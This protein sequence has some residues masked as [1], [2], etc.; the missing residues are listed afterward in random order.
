MLKAFERIRNFGVFDDYS[1]PQDLE[2]FAELNLIYGWNYAGKTTLSRV[3]RSVETQTLHQDYSV[4]RFE[5]STSGNSSIT[6]SSLATASEKIRV[7]NSDFVRDNL[8]WDGE[9]FE[10]ILLLGQQ[11]IEAQKEITTNDALLERLREGYRKK[12]AAIKDHDDALRNKKTERARFIKQALQLVEAFTATHLNQELAK[13]E[14]D[15]AE[16]LVTDE[17]LPRLQQLA[18]ADEKG[19]LPKIQ[20]LA[21]TLSASKPSE[22]IAELLNRKPAMSNT[23]GY[24]AEHAEVANWIRTG[25]PLHDSKDEC[26]FCGNPLDSKRLVSLRAH[27][28]KDVELLESA[29]KQKKADVQRLKLTVA[30]FH[31]SDFYAQF[32]ESL[33]QAQANLKEAISSYNDFL[34]SS[35]V[36]IDEKLLSLFK[37]FECPQYIKGLATAVTQATKVVNA[38]IDENNEVTDTFG[39]EK[40]NAL[41]TLKGHFAA[42]FFV[43][44]KVGRHKVLVSLL[45][46]HKEWYA[47]AGKRFANRNKELQ[48]QIS[49]AQKGRE[50]L[51]SFI[52][53]FLIGSNVSVSVTQVDGAERFQL[54]RDTIPA[55]NLSEGERTAIAFAFFLIKLKEA[56]D[57]GELIVYIDDPVSSLDSNHIFQINAATK[58]F[59]FLHDPAE[60]KT[61]LT[62]KQLFISTHNFEF[63]G[64][65]KELPIQKKTRRKFYFV[66]RLGAGRSTLMAMPTS[67]IRYG[68]EY[69]YLWHVIHDFHTSADKT[70]LEQ[71]LS[72]PNAVRRFVELYTYAKCPSD[73]SVD[74]RADIVFGAETSKRVL[75]LLHHFSHANNLI[76]ISQNDDLLCDIENVV[77]ELVALVQAD[78]QHYDALMRALS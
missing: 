60:N 22:G 10:P 27:F 78:Q 7:F 8:S 30:D 61:K 12:V 31:A 62:I 68:S 26:E 74:R 46:K 47:A 76:G 40:R 34:D 20:R 59:F 24:L 1:R 45:E 33:G 44:E 71:L 64:L 43:S 54:L 51:N 63:F 4:A 16:H 55:K 69:Q 6:E 19:K 72:L 49:Q 65:A 2:D 38:L 35:V 21:L 3:L 41:A 9:A 39:Q 37:E 56:A 14:G 28:S 73:E 32:R 70:N 58:T 18:T 53:K 48:A 15:P 29:L 66:K 11:S 23:I 50:E 42:D 13:V 5:I 75:R 52:G 77:D 57:L 25:L 36:A 17:E 67:I